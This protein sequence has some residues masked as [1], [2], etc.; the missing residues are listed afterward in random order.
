MAKVEGIIDRGRL[1][2]VILVLLPEVYNNSYPRKIMDLVKRNCYIEYPE[3]VC[4][5]D[6]FWDKLVVMIES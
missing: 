2:F 5:Y 6:D 1:D 3:E 4:A